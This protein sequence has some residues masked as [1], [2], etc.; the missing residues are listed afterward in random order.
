MIQR[1]VTHFSWNVH[2]LKYVLQARELDSEEIDENEEDDHIKFR[3]QLQS[4]GVLGRQV[5]KIST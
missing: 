4:I 1:K 2:K 5:S 3:D